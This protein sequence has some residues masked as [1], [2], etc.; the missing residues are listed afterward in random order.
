MSAFFNSQFS[1][2]SL[3]WMC[4]S[5]INNK[6]INRLHERCLFVIYNNKQSSF[7]ELVEKDSSV[8]IH[9]RY[10]QSLATEMFSVSRNI[11]PP[12]M[13]DNF[14]QK[15]NSRYNLVQIFEFSGPLV[16]TVYHRSKSVSFLEPKI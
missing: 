16:K 14:K 7:S 9:I 6:K 2:F 15:N 11:L 12:I 3:I 5:R 13:N 10:I 4:H 8:S 1:Y